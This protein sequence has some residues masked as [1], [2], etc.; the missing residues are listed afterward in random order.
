MGITCSRSVISGASLATF[1]PSGVQCCYYR[2]GLPTPC[3]SRKSLRYK[4]EIA[5]VDA[6][7]RV[8]VRAGIPPPRLTGLAPERRPDNP[9]IP[10][11]HNTIT[12][13]VSRSSGGGTE[14]H[15][16][17]TMAGFSTVIDPFFD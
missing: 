2:A 1:S 16:D 11:I 5:D 6:P 10:T 15:I 14:E 4:R 17:G 7:I 13:N 3:A 8:D 9:D 12:V